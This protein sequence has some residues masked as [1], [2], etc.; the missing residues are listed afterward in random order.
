MQHIETPANKNFFCH[1][2]APQHPGLLKIPLVEEKIWGYWA[3]KAR[4]YPLVTHHN[5][6]PE[7]QFF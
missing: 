3:G 6:F 7:S 5:R 4:Y 2:A 1:S